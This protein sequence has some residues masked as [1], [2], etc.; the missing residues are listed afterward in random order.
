MAQ[1]VDLVI[2]QGAFARLK[3]EVQNEDGVYVNMESGTA[4]MVIRQSSS[5]SENIDELTTEN[6]RIEIDGHTLILLFTTE[7]T[8]T[9]PEGANRYTL[10]VTTSD[11]ETIRIMEGEFFV[12]PSIS[13]VSEDDDEEEEEDDGD[14]DDS[15]NDSDE[16]ETYPKPSKFDDW[17]YWP[18]LDSDSSTG[19]PNG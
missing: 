14:S 1:E 7:A 4:R 17:Y 3:V 16:S 12:T 10:D 6:G 15:D 9:Y 19:V 8:S 2:D 5:S 13:V 11:G 18:R